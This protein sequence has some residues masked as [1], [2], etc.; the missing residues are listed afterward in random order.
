MRSLLDRF[1][2]FFMKKRNLE[3]CKF[4][5]E[6]AVNPGLIYI[7]A[8]KNSMDNFVMAMESLMREKLIKG[9]EI[10]REKSRL[11]QVTAQTMADIISGQ[12]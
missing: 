5:T 3:Y 6:H 7:K 11:R 10:E 1:P 2:E 9:Q 8:C 4:M 12:F